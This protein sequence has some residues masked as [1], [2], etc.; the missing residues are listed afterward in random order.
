MFPWWR[1]AW[2]AC[3]SFLRNRREVIH[4]DQFLP[5]ISFSLLTPPLSSTKS[6]HY[7]WNV[8]MVRKS[9]WHLCTI[10]FHI[11]TEKEQHLHWEGAAFPKG[12]FPKGN[13]K[14]LHI[15][16]CIGCHGPLR[17]EL[18]RMRA[19][20]VTCISLCLFADPSH[21]RATTVFFSGKKKKKGPN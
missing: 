7:R 16:N 8:L 5:E 2:D 20:W 15:S 9:S 12:K 17:Q 4:V 1:T 19:M 21:F 3:L 18:A 6:I 10:T 11:C 14:C 13:F